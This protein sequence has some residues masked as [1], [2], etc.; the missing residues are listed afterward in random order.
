M[1]RVSL[2]SK[3]QFN[4]NRLESLLPARHWARQQGFRYKETQ[5]HTFIGERA[6]GVIT[7]TATTDSVL[8]RGRREL[9]R[10]RASKL[11]TLEVMAGGAAGTPAAWAE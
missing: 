8:E 3:V 10:G 1:V 4:K 7:D 11:R 5:A 6:H 2:C 9:H